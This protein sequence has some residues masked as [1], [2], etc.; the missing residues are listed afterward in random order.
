MQRTPERPSRTTADLFAY[1]H[2]LLGGQLRERAQQRGQL[3]VG[4]GKSIPD[5]IEDLLF[6]GTEAHG[7]SFQASVVAGR[8]DGTGGHHGA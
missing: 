2:L 5:R 1:R 4:C 7:W 3:R 6:P 8:A